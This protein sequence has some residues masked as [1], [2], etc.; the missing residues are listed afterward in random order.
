MNPPVPFLFPVPYPLFQARGRGPDME[1]PP[2]RIMM[3]PQGE[4]TKDFITAN[5]G[6]TL[7]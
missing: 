1:L 3:P 6:K 2:H 7:V 5:T 4:V